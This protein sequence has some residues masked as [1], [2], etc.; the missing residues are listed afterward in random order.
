MANFDAQP[1]N[2][3]NSQAL[4]FTSQLQVANPFDPANLTWVEVENSTSADWAGFYIL[5]TMNQFGIN[6]MLFVGTG[7]AASEVIVS[8]TPTTQSYR[9]WVGSKFIPIPIAAGTRVSVA[10]SCNYAAI[11]YLQIVGVL[12]ANF[13]AEPAYTKYHTGPYDLTAT[14]AL[15]G[16]WV[17]L[18]PGITQ[19][20]KSAYTEI[21]FTGST[22]NL[23]NGDSLDTTYSQ[24][25]FVTNGN[26]NTANRVSDNFVDV[27]YGAAASE[28]IW[29]G[30][31]Q[32][33]MTANEQTPFTEPL[34]VPTT[35]AVATSRWSARMQ[36]STNND[37]DR[38]QSIL[39]Y[40]VV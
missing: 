12:S 26:F 16:K 24:F 18:D 39:L 6:G 35:N 4:S 23:L 13:S 31:I 9:N 21:S 19:N 29:A 34:I 7:A 27:A 2:L 25:G 32:A 11:H 36:S 10:A 8:V 22:A 33:K 5:S 1:V 38:K 40:G 14:T 30:D 3:A 17:V 37:P 20:T 15:Y 28:T